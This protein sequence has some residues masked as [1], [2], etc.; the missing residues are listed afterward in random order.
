MTDDFEK[1]INSMSDDEYIDR[2]ESDR[3]NG[4]FSDAQKEKALNIREPPNDT[5]L[6]ELEQSQEGNVEIR[7][8]TP[9]PQAPTSRNIIYD[10]RDIPR[11]PEQPPSIRKN[12]IQRIRKPKP[13]PTTQQV[14]PVQ[15]SRPAPTR[16]QKLVSRI[17]RFFRI[18]DKGQEDRYI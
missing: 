9:L 17:K 15:T 14:Q 4:G 1:W 12:I 5:E 8:T 3:D 13:Q 16:I 18:M 10:N 11:Q 7:P 6:R 2:L